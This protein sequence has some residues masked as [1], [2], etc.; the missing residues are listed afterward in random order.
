MGQLAEEFDLGYDEPDQESE[1][2]EAELSAA[3]VS[4][5][6]MIVAIG[7]PF[8]VATEK[9]PEDARLG[10]VHHF[11]MV[12]AFYTARLD[13]SVCAVP[14]DTP[15]GDERFHLLHHPREVAAAPDLGDWILQRYPTMG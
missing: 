15:E 5:K 6:P 2:L 9:V 7:A 11:V 4:A 12:F 3:G 13:V 1:E 8:D 14:A 10:R